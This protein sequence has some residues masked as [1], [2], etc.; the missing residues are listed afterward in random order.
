MAARELK[1]LKRLHDPSS[2]ILDT[3]YRIEELNVHLT[4][5]YEDETG[6]MCQGRITFEFF[7]ALSLENDSNGS[8]I[9]PPQSMTLY[10]FQS[11]KR[12]GFRGFKIWL[13][14]AEMI[15]ISCKSVLIGNERF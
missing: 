1:V 12:E 10:E 4:Y 7:A 11:N 5:E 3:S 8:G 6:K 9:L 14:D 13:P 2:G 15:E